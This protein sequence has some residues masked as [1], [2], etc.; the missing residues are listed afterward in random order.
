MT[1]GSSCGI[2]PFMSKIE[3]ER[4]RLI[5]A[6]S[7]G[8]QAKE[9]SDKRTREEKEA[10]GVCRTIYYDGVAVVQQYYQPRV[11]TRESV[12]KRLGTLLNRVNPF[13]TKRFR[14]DVEIP[15]LE[16]GQPSVY[17]QLRE[18][19]NA[20]RQQ[21]DMWVR[22]YG[23][24]LRTYRGEG[25]DIVQYDRDIYFYVSKDDPYKR[26]YKRTDFDPL[27]EAQEWREVMD[28]VLK[29]RP[30]QRVA[31]QQQALNREAG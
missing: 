17:V 2:F 24:R 22:E 27:K 5:E 13:Y 25:W 31:M 12:R 29:L 10:D 16:E 19:G 8:A 15:I 30:I 23:H 7:K 6:R 9:E 26:L 14:R 11:A 4:A 21:L 28:A 3:E 1:F 18:H 20:N